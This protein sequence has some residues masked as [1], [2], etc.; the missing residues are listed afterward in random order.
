MDN[1]DKN[2]VDQLKNMMNNGQLD[3]VI[4]QISPE[5]IQNFSN[6]MNNSSDNN[7][8]NKSS[9]HVQNNNNN[10][11]SSNSSNSNMFDLNNI[12]MNTI[13]KMKSIMDKMN[14]SND[15]RANLLYSLKPY[16]REE[17]KG[18]VDQYANLL[19]FANI[20]ELLRNDNNKE[21]KKNE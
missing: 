18:K 6:M 2:T 15:P 20:A 5:M 16:L 7:L 9:E 14:N 19:N 11:H 12:D 10:V 13:L 17:R 1:I 4:K 21:N 3:D 8:D